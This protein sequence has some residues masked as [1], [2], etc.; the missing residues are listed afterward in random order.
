MKQQLQ[1]FVVF[2]SLGLLAFAAEYFFP[3][4]QVRYRSVIF[5]DLIALGIYNLCFFLV[6]PFTDRI[7]VP[8]YAPAG[9]A[10]VSIVWKLALFYIIED[11]GLYWVHRFMHTQPL[12]RTHKWH[13]YPNY[14]YWLAGIRTSIPHIILFNLTFIAAKP[15]LVGVPKW[16][17]L[18]ITMEH[19]ARNTWMHMNVSWKSTWLEYLIVTPRYHHIHHSADPAHYRSNLGSLLTIWDRMFGTYFEP[20]K[21]NRTLTFGIGEKVGPVRLVLGV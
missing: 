18:L 7:P 14:M 8:N 4:R 6:V 12:W 1:L 20:S 17:F 13:H 9:W 16:I 10:N 21:A 15:L 2:W 5:R 19:I 3:A 11:F